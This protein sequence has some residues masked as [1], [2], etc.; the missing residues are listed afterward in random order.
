VSGSPGVRVNDRFEGWELNSSPLQKQ[1][2]LFTVESSLLPPRVL[3]KCLQPA[4]GRKT[5]SK[6]LVRATL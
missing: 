2:V 3:T 4:F 5:Q 1:H 6:E